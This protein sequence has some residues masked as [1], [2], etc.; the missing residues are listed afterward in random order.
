MNGCIS[1]WKSLD[2]TVVSRI[3]IT[4]RQSIIVSTVGSV[5]VRVTGVEPAW[6]WS[7]TKCLTDR[8]HP[9]IQFWTIIPRSRWKTKFFL[10]VVIYVVKA[11]FWNGFAVRKNPANDRVARGSGLWLYP[12]WMKSTTLPNVACYQLHYTRIFGCH[13]YSTKLVRFKVFSCLWSFM[14]SKRVSCPVLL[15][16]KIPQMPV[17][18]G[19]PGFGCSYRG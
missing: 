12:S 17:L 15:S 9:D 13:D 18:Q 6:P 16:G 7:Q 4:N 1:E 3:K 5:M 10:S 11:G 2:M 14:W 19:V 8:L